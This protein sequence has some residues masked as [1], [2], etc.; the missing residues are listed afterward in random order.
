MKR[1]RGIWSS[2]TGGDKV[3]V[4]IVLMLVAVSS[5]MAVIALLKRP[6]DISNPDVAFEVQ[7]SEPIKAANRPDRRVDWPRYGYDI[8]R[9]KFLNAQRVKPPFRKLWSYKQDQLIEFAPIVVG[10]RLYMIDN[11]GVFIALDVDTGKVVWKK[12]HGSLNASSP[13]FSKG[14]LYA[15][16]LSP[17]QA[18]AIRARDGKPLW[19]REL[20]ARAESSPMV[21]RG[22]MYFGTES[23]DFFALKARNG[24]VIWSTKLAGSVKAA[25]AFSDGTLYVGDYAGQMYAIRASDGAVRW[26]TSDLGVGL[27]RSGRFYSTPAVA[28]GRVYA[29]NV[30]GRVYSFD[31]GSGEIAW[32]HSAGDYV[33]S[34]IAAART[35]ATKPAVYFGSHDRR[36]Y[37]LEAKSGN[38]IWEAAPGG[39]VSGP[40]TVVG[41]VAYVST[42]SGNATVGLDLKTGRRVFKFDDGE[43]GPVVSDGVRLF[44]LGGA[45]VFALE[46]VKLHGAGYKANDGFKGVVPPAELRRIRRKQAM[47]ERGGA[48]GQEQGGAGQGEGAA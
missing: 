42:F 21:I 30:D 5:V 31:Q 27:G 7:T 41:D 20:P 12:Q 3:V 6:A 9:T 35:K 1:A 46:P 32:T 23:G 36:A 11:D 16:N 17:Q 38:V 15:V 44:V 13:A 34:G 18:L 28:F 40:A 47:R 37:A 45:A 4:A 2:L 29:G 14:V 19:K 33:Y 22:K 39:Q 43:Y 25:P 24:K 10:K 26:Q 8:E 48:D